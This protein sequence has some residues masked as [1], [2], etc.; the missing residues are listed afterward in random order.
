MNDGFEPR[1]DVVDVMVEGNQE[2]P[3]MKGE[4]HT[5]ETKAEAL[6]V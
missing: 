4:G 2:T 1:I 6:Q 3:V 5:S